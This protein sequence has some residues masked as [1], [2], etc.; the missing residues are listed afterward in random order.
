MTCILE[1]TATAAAI[2]LLAACAGTKF[3]WEQTRAVRAGMTADEL[4]Q[5]MGKPYAVTT[6][7]NQTIWTYSLMM[8]SP[9]ASNH[10]S[11]RTTSGAHYADTGLSTDAIGC[12]R[13]L[14]E[15]INGPR[16]WEANPWVWVVDF[17]KV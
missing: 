10:G 15:Q 12:Y 17:R 14:W 13:S 3:D 11:A 16:A 2:A 9:K 8:R 7:G 1:A 4:Q 6:R 5:R